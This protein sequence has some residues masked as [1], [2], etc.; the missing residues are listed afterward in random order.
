M[1]SRRL[2]RKIH[3]HLKRAS[4]LSSEGKARAAIAAV[5]AALQMDQ[6]YLPALSMLGRLKDEMERAKSAAPTPEMA[7]SSEVPASEKEIPVSAETGNGSHARAGAVTRRAEWLTFEQRVR[8][9]RLA[10]CLRHANAAIEQGELTEA[11]G[12]LEEASRLEPS[13]AEVRSLLVRLGWKRAGRIEATPLH[14]TEAGTDG[15]VESP[16]AIATSSETRTDMPAPGQATRVEHPADQESMPEEQWRLAFS[17]E[18]AQTVA[19]RFFIE[20]DS[21]PLAG[22]AEEQPSENLE[23]PTEPVA[24]QVWAHET[25]GGSA[26]PY[27]DWAEPG[28]AEWWDDSQP[29][30]QGEEER[31]TAGETAPRPGSAR[32]RLAAALT[33]FLLGAVF[34]F[35][36]G[37]SPDLVDPMSSTGERAG[38]IHG[39][40]T[41]MGVM[42][43]IA[44]TEAD[45]AQVAVIGA[46]SPQPEPSSGPAVLSD[47]DVATSPTRPAATDARRV[48]EPLQRNP[49]EGQELSDAGPM[50]ATAVEPQPST[51]PPLEAQRPDAALARPQVERTQPPAMGRH[52][53]EQQLA[54]AGSGTA[55][56][57]R[58]AP[59]SVATAPTVP[60]QRVASRTASETVQTAVPRETER[61]STSGTGGRGAE[62]GADIT[63]AASETSILPP[64]AAA[65]PTAREPAEV[66][67]ARVDTRAEPAVVS[68]VSARE[69]AEREIRSTL[70]RYV[71]AYEKLDAGAAKQVWPSVNE[72][73][74]TRAFQGLESQALSL[75]DCSVDVASSRAVAFCQG[76]A[77]YVRRIGNRT[78]VTEPREWVFTL[79]RAEEGWKIE[80]ARAQRKGS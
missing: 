76:T 39:V 19:R 37:T 47:A 2:V 23:R 31:E 7:S 33:L 48:Q 68:A 27:I 26:Q 54:T 70:D 22:W 73:A 13:S 36:T 38:E 53:S 62:S 52:A 24:E 69:V 44:A 20:P 57:R 6:S 59:P 40:E 80:A 77:S 55:V 28:H 25:H 16:V 78:T 75:Q 21:D 50:R 61:T 5:E 17:L 74:L 67:A 4:R 64:A 58:Q 15:E 46:G 14:E 12:A 35:W 65:P 45:N 9:R 71:V 3:A 18:D 66:A 34:H 41:T 8:N 72:Q 11:E 30:A 42:A 63:R 1:T 49:S 60:E 79:R 32:S 43:E 29:Y 10:T 56:E 51:Q